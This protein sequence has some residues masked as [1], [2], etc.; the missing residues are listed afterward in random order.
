MIILSRDNAEFSVVP[1]SSRRRPAVVPRRPEL[2]QYAKR[3]GLLS[4]VYP[5]PSFPGPQSARRVG[6]WLNAFP[7]TLVFTMDW[8]CQT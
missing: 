6:H 2:R 1:P 8:V 5:L 3:P 4:P 7:R